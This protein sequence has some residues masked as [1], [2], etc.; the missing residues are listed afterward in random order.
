MISTFAGGGVSSSDGIPATASSI[1]DPHGGVFDKYGN[2]YFVQSQSHKISRVSVT[3][4]ITTIAG[5]G[6]LGYNGDGIPASSAKL[7]YPNAVAVDTSGNVYITDAANHRIRKVTIAT[8]L[9]ST[10]AGTGSSGFAG[11]GIPATSA[12][13]QSPWGICFDKN[14]NLYFSD[15]LN[16]RIR[17]ISSSGIISTVT[18]N[19]TSGYSGDGLAATVAQCGL[20]MGLRTDTSGN[21]VFADF[22]N[23]RVRK[24]NPL[25][26]ITTIAGNGT[27]T[28]S[29]DG[30]PA[31]SASLD[32]LDIEIEN[33]NGNVFII[34]HANNRIRKIDLSGIIHTVAGT[35]IAGFN[36]DGILA[37][38]AQISNPGGL[39]MDGCGNIYF[40]DINNAR[41]RKITFN[42]CIPALDEKEF[43]KNDKVSIYP[44]PAN[45]IIIIEQINTNALY[46]I[47]N[48]L[49]SVVQNG[50]LKAG[51]A[52]LS[53]KHFPPGIYM[54]LLTDGEGKRTVHKIIK[55]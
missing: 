2:C 22:G 31:T 12:I 25:G 45:D 40:G 39:A 43:F 42:P 11:E 26:I 27:Y 8:G 18:G 17:K 24:I 16:Y 50:H 10:I 36:G 34:D 3:G 13:I 15:G 41:F 20:V 9:I 30:M 52:I 53:I 1:D 35:G 54:L 28:Y 23:S 38:A 51:N 19:G 6:S 46:Q 5:T 48:I 29:G 49:G 14:N 33:N 7:N 47:S 21:L 4:I 37:T 32:P 44:N 55:D